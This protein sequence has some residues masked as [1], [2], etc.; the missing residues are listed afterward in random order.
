MEIFV[1]IIVVALIV[2]AL[3]FFNKTSVKTQSSESEIITQPS[4]SESIKT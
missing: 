4:T 3:A 2:L 1:I